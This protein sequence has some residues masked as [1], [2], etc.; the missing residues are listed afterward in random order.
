MSGG[1]SPGLGYELHQSVSLLTG[2]RLL[3]WAAV[4]QVRTAVHGLY[5]CVSPG[6]EY[7]V[8]LDN[9]SVMLVEALKKNSMGAF[10][11]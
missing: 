6:L 8:I 4:P 11:R 9:R 10:D 7:S 5:P 1:G 2:L 3:D